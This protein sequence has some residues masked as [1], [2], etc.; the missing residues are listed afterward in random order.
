M[1]KNQKV[2]TD[3]KA[4]VPAGAS[5]PVPATGT[6]AKQQLPFEEVVIELDHTG[7]W[8]LDGKVAMAFGPGAELIGNTVGVAITKPAKVIVNGEE[9][10]NP[11]ILYDDIGQPSVLWFR[12]IGVYIGK[13]GMIRYADIPDRI[14][15]SS[16][17]AERATKAKKSKDTPSTAAIFCTKTQAQAWNEK[18]K[19][20]GNDI[21]WFVPTQGTEIGIAFNLAVNCKGITKL[22]EDIIHFRKAIIRR[23]ET[24]TN[25]RVIA[26]LVAEYMTTKDAEFVTIT[27]YTNNPNFKVTKVVTAKFTVQKPAPASQFQGL[28][29]GLYQQI[30]RAIRE[31][32]SELRDRALASFGSMYGITQPEII[33]VNPDTTPDPIN[34]TGD[35]E[36]ADEDEGKGDGEIAKET[37]SESETAETSGDVNLDPVP[38]TGK[39]TEFRAYVKTQIPKMSDKQKG[40]LREIVGPDCA[41]D[42]FKGSDVGKEVMKYFIG[43]AGKEQESEKPSE[44]GEVTTETMRKFLNEK[45][46]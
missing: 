22:Q 46:G 44:T 13:D 8:T 45:L 18:A 3:G 14:D 43:I 20:P 16:Y 1:D 26:T 37:T 25:R 4:L 23:F 34:I 33:E 41:L 7:A 10:D 2:S 9:K 32:N 40:E 15:I 31:D 21:W 24:A 36:P 30:A 17:I 12:K 27:P 42:G 28:E 5:P 19:E 29:M 11:H 39:M 35:F 38:I 6:L